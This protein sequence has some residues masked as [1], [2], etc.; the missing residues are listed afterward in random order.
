MFAAAGEGPIKQ[1]KVV[2][3]EASVDQAG[4][5]K[6]LG[7]GFVEFRDHQ[8]RACSAGLLTWTFIPVLLL[9]C[10]ASVAPSQ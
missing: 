4:K 6:S 7:F 5:S 9:G 3:D 8:V 1:V 2:R 10:L